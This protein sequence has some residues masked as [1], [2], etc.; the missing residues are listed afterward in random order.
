MPLTVTHLRFALQV[1]T[2]FKSDDREGRKRGYEL[3][4]IGV[5]RLKALVHK[6]YSQPDVL[7]NEYRQER[8]SW[9]LF[10]DILDKLEENLEEKEAFAVGLRR[11]A[12]ACVNACRMNLGSG[13]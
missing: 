1:A 11:R 13:Q 2:L 5:S 4:Q 7:I 9:N 3:I 8:S 10:Y 12:L 6:L